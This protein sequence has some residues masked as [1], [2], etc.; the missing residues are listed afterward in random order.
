MAAGRRMGRYSL[1]IGND[2][3]QVTQMTPSATY[4][5]DLPGYSTT[6]TPEQHAAHRSPK[7]TPYP[8]NLVPGLDSR[9]SAK[10]LMKAATK[11]HITLT[12]KR[13]GKRRKKKYA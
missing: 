1:Y 12:A 4:F 10:G 3:L 13:T 6:F 5:S 2:S 8:E 9:K 11:K 7:G